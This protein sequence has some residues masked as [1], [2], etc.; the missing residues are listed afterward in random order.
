MYNYYAKLFT[1]IGITKA[2]ILLDV[3]IIYSNDID[4]L[5]ER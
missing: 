4:R 1:L 2:I 5:R 3:I